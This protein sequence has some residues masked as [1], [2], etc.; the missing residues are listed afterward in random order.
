ML[1]FTARTRFKLQAYGNPLASDENEKEK[2]LGDM[3]LPKNGKKSTAT[4]ALGEHL[5][6]GTLYGEG[7]GGH[8]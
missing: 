3:A 5:T 4:T 2:A 7:P 8:L 6:T 1:G